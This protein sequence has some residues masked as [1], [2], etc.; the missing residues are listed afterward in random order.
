M[1]RR[2]F[3]SH[4]GAFAGLVSLPSPLAFSE[5]PRAPLPVAGVVTE[6]GTNTHADV[7]LG[8]ILDGFDQQGGPGSALK[9]VGLYTDQIPKRDLSRA[10]ADKHGFSIASTIDEA[11]TGGTD[12]L[13]AAGVI[14]IG[15]H[16]D[17]PQTPDT[18]QTMYP[19]RR[20]FDG[21]VD[22]FRRVGA[23]V[24]V[25]SDKH[26]A[27]N[28]NDAL[29]MYQT[30]A[31]MKIPFMAGS[32]CPVAWRMPPLSLPIGC[33]IEAALAI[34]YGGFES[35][36]FHALETLQCMVE[37]RAGGETGVAH[38][39]VLQGDAIWQARDAGQ[40][41]D[42][43]LQAALALMPDVRPGDPQTLLKDRAAFYQI[44]YRDGLRATVAMANGLAGQF[45]FAAKLRGREKPVATWFKLQEEAPFGHFAYLVRAIE[46][47][48]HTGT[49]AYPVERTLLTTGVLD[50]VMH[51]LAEGG[52]R[53]ETPELA[54]RY[55]PADWPFANQD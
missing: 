13:Q 35:Y 14:S 40:W 51:S 52:K 18:Q 2:K 31:A 6:Y 36:G 21:I 42:E 43:L 37:R 46:S 45:G 24:P 27:F 16:G 17:Y 48:I 11:L 29:H 50:R 30:A 54:I 7:I 9:L 23:V 39:H 19:R 25:F 20:F 33:E 28:W 26:L 38:V 1:D 4:A 8:K 49:P 5:D 12:R 3:L 41:Q 34:G 15:E 47:M 44:E 32:S 55:Q 22:T 10:L 53:F